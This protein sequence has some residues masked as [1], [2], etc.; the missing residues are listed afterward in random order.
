M[1]LARII[2][3]IMLLL[4]HRKVTA[5]RLAEMFE[6]NVRTIYRDVELINLAGIPI[7]ASR[8][9]GGGIGI[10]EEY[11]V[12]KGLFTTADI[13]S[14]LIALGSSPLS[15]EE[16]L[17]TI[18]KIKGLIPKEQMRNIELK[19]RQIVVDHS[20]WHGRRLMP[21]SFAR[22]KSALELNRLIS[23]HYY[24]GNG[25]ESHRITEPYQLMLKESHWYLLAYCTL[26]DDF[27]IF[28]V[29]RMSE[30]MMLEDTFTPKEFEYDPND[31]PETPDEII[32]TLLVDE[33]LR[34]LMADYCGRDNLKAGE[35]NKLQADFPFVESDF[36][37]GLLL[38]FGNKCECLKPEK[39]RREL[40][41]RSGEL[42]K[43]YQ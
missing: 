35:D 43:L 10:M 5:A 41:K 20:P 11:K 15:G 29:S 34:G 40:K 23:F 39:V 18:A 27:R 21:N 4:Q 19:A 26:R 13:T 9:V 28:R 36:G 24:D 30:I 2:S 8:G 17:A 16:V 14:L 6:V 7:T 32:I 1:K 42:F 38:S 22:I 31:S 12:E 25:R 37:Y 33:S 3:I